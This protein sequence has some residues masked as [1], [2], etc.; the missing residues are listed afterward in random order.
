R[1]P[2][3]LSICAAASPEGCMDRKSSIVGRFASSGRC[4]LAK[5]AVSFARGPAVKVPTKRDRSDAESAKTRRG[6]L[7]V[8][9]STKGR[10]T[11]V[12]KKGNPLLAPNVEDDQ[13]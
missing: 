8:T 10:Q 5:V 3:T 2:S 7:F 9:W 12:R 11:I 1:K 6:K 4:S 13:S